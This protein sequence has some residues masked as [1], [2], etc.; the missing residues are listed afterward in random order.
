MKDRRHLCVAYVGCP[1]FPYGLA[2]IQKMRLVARSLVEAGADV[3][4]IS[5]RSV[6]PAGIEP[7]LSAS[8]SFEGIRYVY[9]SGDPRRPQTF[10]R[11]TLK[12]IAGVAG[13]IR[14]I[15]S[16][17]REGRLDA[18]IVVSLDFLWVLYYSILSRIY[19]F[20]IV[21]DYVEYVSGIPTRTGWYYKCN[22]RL[23]DRYAL[24][25]A[26]GVLPISDFLADHVQRT[27]PGKPSF[28]IPVLV[29]MHRFEEKPAPHRNK[30]F[31]YCGSLAYFEIV[32]FILDAYRLLGRDSDG[33]GLTLV[34]NGRPDQH[35][36]LGEEL[37][38]RGYPASVKVYSHL[39]D[40][41]LTALLIDASALLIPLRPTL[42]DRARFPHKIGEYLATGCPVITTKYGE[43]PKYL[44]DGESAV[45]AATYD[46]HKYRDKLLWTI[47]HPEEA[48]RVGARG[49]EVARLHFDYRRYGNG[50]KEFLL[51]LCDGKFMPATDQTGNISA[52][53]VA[54]EVTET[55]ATDYVRD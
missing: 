38:R 27:V 25:L 50:L 47:R 31:L 36:R 34:V 45:I 42:Q 9:T 19:H 4:V 14:Y 3:T 35:R 46:V 7:A 10:L 28:R 53:R 30:Y 13:E 11:R 17:S 32:T 41:V 29:D 21:Y 20:T 12:K 43:I 16:L 48:K 24:S 40:E 22:D 8:G 37:A 55:Q 33:W 18:A 51:S 44:T 2:A 39:T 6:L 5:N 52:R 1:G 23:I 15:K 49:R 54:R 26:D